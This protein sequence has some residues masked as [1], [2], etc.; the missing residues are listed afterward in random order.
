MKKINLKLVGLDGNAFSIM[1]AFQRQAR[2]E[3]WDKQEIDAVLNEARSGD[4]DHLLS[5]IM[6]HCEDPSEEYDDDDYED[7]EDNGFRAWKGE[8]ANV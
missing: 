6:D 4:Y 8:Y 3:D 5:T 2:K 1:G 7:E